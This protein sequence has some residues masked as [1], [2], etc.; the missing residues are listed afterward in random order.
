MRVSEAMSSDVQL[1]QPDQTI[2][3]AAGMMEKANAGVIPVGEGDQLT[4]MLSDRDISVRAVAQGMGPDTPVREVMSYG[5]K[6]C[7][8]DQDT[9]EVAR[10]MGDQQLRRLLVVNRDKRLVGILSLGDL[11]M[12]EGPKTAGATVAEISEGGEAS[13]RAS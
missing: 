5:V 11:A 10:N 9:E 6:Y 2:Q 3:E 4:G 12:A 8:E 13:L 7:F 1:V